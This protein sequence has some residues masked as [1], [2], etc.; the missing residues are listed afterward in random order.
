MHDK[1]D[2]ALRQLARAMAAKDVDTLTAA[3][4]VAGEAG[5]APANLQKG[6]DALATA[7]QAAT[8]RQ[9]VPPHERAA[10]LQ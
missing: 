1:Q 9:Q 2:T 8:H 5:V 10:V 6:R 4:A 7:T 3:L